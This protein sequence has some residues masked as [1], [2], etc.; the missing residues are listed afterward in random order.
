VIPEY[1]QEKPGKD[2]PSLY[3]DRLYQGFRIPFTLSALSDI[4]YAYTEILNPFLTRKIIKQSRTLPDQL[5]NDKVLFKGIVNEIS[6][7]VPYA[8]EQSTDE[9]ILKTTDAVKLFSSEISQ[10]YMKEIFPEE[11]LHKVLAKLQKPP[12]PLKDGI[13]SKLKKVIG[14][15]LPATIKDRLITNMPKPVLDSSILAF[16]V[17]ITGKIYKMFTED[18]AQAKD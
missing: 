12:I 18:V 9:D 7:K 13:L 14:R 15:Y 4:K 3:R 6:P 17:F 16:R 1:F 10:D 8:I 2:T 11:F 5:R